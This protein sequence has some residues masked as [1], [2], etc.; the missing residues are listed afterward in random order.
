MI[1]KELYKIVYLGSQKPLFFWLDQYN[2]IRKNVL[3]EPEMNTQ[4]LH[5]TN[6]KLNF[7]KLIKIFEEKNPNELDLAK[8]LDSLSPIFSIDNTKKDILKLV[9]DYIQ[10]SVTFVNLAQKTESFRLK[11]AQISIHWSQKEKT[12][13]DDRL[14]KN[15][16]MQF[17]LEYYLTIYKKIIDATSI[18]EKKSYIENTQVD[19]GAGGVPG[20]WTDFQSMDVA[21]KFIFLILDDDLRNALLD[22]YFETRIRFMKLHV[23]KNKQEQP[24]IDYAGISLEELILSFRQLL[25][26]FLS[27]Y[28]KQ[29]TEQLKSYFFTPYGN[30]PLIR[31]IH[32]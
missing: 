19:L 17:C 2:R 26:V 32:L 20:L 3:L 6:V 27:T 18:E 9:N 30:K 12:E 16:G 11:R 15:E 23:I 24:H 28:Q 29:G 14:F 13:F 10:K 22:I 4:R 31:D 5:E 1:L 8:A 21:E 7:Q 25:L